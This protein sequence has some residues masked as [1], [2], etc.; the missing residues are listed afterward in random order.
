MS[1]T[2]KNLDAAIAKYIR[3]FTFPVGVKFLK[4]GEELPAHTKV[5]TRDLGHPVAICQDISIARKYGWALTSIRR[6]RPASSR[7]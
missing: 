7:R 6:M 1:E 2:V 3:P 4:E 5:P